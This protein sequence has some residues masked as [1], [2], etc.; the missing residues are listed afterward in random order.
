M[1][2]IDI[3]VELQNKIKR[4]F[5]TRCQKDFTLQGIKQK[6]ENGTATMEDT[7][8]YA[9][10]MGE[11]LRK[12]IESTIKPDDLPGEKMYYNIAQS[13]LE[14][15]LRDN[16]EDVNGICAEVQRALDAKKG[17]GLKPQKADF[18]AERIRAAIGG[19]A[20]KETAE[21]AIQVL[22][23][24][25]ENI[26]GS[27]QTDYIKKNAE[28]RNK[29]GLNC[30]IERKDGHNCCDWCAKLSG[31]YRYPDE[32]PKDVYRRHDNC[33]CDV[34]YVSEKGR[35][36]VHTQQLNWSKEKNLEY[37]K[38]LDAEKKAKRAEYKANGKN[39][40]KVRFKPSESAARRERIE[41]AESL[42]K[43]MKLTRAEA[44]AVEFNLMSNS[45]RPKYS[46]KT[47]AIS[48]DKILISTKAVKNSSFN[49]IT[50]VDATKRDK[51]V[52]LAEKLL[53]E[54]KNE[55]P[56]GYEIPQVAVIDFD[57]YN[58]GTKA[59]AGYHDGILFLNSKYDTKGKIV[60]YVNSK[61]GQFANTSDHAPILHEIGHDYYEKSVKALAKSRNI[62]YNNAKDIIDGR[63]SEYIH[64]HNDDGLF[65]V[66]NISE[67]ADEGYS[68]H[69]YTEIIAE[70]FSVRDENTYAKELLELLRGELI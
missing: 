53:S 15:L 68:D 17:I 25:A 60:E 52:R 58:L 65:L 19:A 11:L 69:S 55:L 10:R 66:N 43:P 33:T 26:T 20:V 46:D 18:P 5:D 51:A 1:A 16:Y 21:H 29:A 13:I 32:V 54:I 28:F 47:T 3:G 14:P 37:L 63:I 12:S 42:P 59:I 4:A 44:Q 8:I 49:I 41:R 22:G 57:R 70:C 40:Q 7:S 34:S 2:D 23:R 50:D 38:Q 6:I 67:Y 9:R 61:K 30:F 39:L 64:A 62:E 24:T 36:N 35:R 45:F 56:Q 48:I 27:F 31:K